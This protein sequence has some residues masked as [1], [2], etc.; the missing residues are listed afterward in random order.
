MT[1]PLEHITTF[2]IPKRV[3][4]DTIKVLADAGNEGH[5]AFVVWGAVIDPPGEAL[6]FRSAV[7]PRQT[8]HKTP[9]GLL[10][11]VDGDAL[12]QINRKFYQRGELL[13]GQVHSH[14]TTAYH[15]STDDHFPLVTLAGALSVVVPDFAAHAPGDIKDWAW[16]RLVG[17]ALW[18]E[19]TRN[20]H[21]ELIED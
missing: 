18:D 8:G 14:P 9:D 3:I 21:I 13:A 12:F 4:A 16:Y 2:R 10:V 6:A 19:L 11:T 1:S 5:E 7:A 17:P 20:D 15:S